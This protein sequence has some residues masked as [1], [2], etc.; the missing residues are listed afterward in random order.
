MQAE[1]G[2]EELRKRYHSSVKNVVDD[3][4]VAIIGGADTSSSV[5]AILL[6]LLMRNPTAKTRLR[7]EVDAFFDRDEDIRD[8]TKL[9]A[10]PYLNACM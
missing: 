5:M 1:S 8:H 2:T 4:F 7:E 6:Y 3:A 9:A 10:M